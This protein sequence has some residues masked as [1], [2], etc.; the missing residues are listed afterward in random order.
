MKKILEQESSLALLSGLKLPRENSQR[1][2]KKERPLKMAKQL[3]GEV[4]RE[5]HAVS[6]KT[7]E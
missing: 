5:D 2:E 6:I 4:I 1:K 7:D 3:A